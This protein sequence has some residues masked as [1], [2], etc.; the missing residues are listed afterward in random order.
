M[1]NKVVTKLLGLAILL[2]AGAGT[3]QALDASHF[4]TTSKLA[5]GKWVKIAIPESGMYELTSTELAEMGFSSIANV[6][7]YGVG[8]N[9]ISEVLDGSAPDDLQPV[10]VGRTGNK[11]FFYANG[12]VSFSMTNYNSTTLPTQFTRIIN[13]YSNYGYYFLTESTG[14]DNTVSTAAAATVTNPA[15]KTSSLGYWRH[16][17]ELMSVG[18]SGKEFMGEDFTNEVL[19]IPYSI[20]NLVG[21]Q[22]TVQTDVAANA[23]ALSYVSTC[24]HSGSATD[25]V[26][27]SLSASKI[28]VPASVYVFYNEASPTA[29]VTL[30]DPQPEGYLQPGIN[31]SSATANLL[32]AKL[33]YFIITYPRLNVLPTDDAQGHQLLM[34]FD[35][36]TNTDRVVLPGASATTQVWNITNHNSPVAMPLTTVDGGRAFTNGN[37]ADYLIYM[38][39][40]PAQTLK[41]IA[42]YKHVENQNLHAATTPDMVIVTNSYFHEQAQRIAD[43][44]TAKDGMTVLVVD[45]EKI[46]NEFSSGTPDAMGIRMFNKMLYDRNPSKLK[47]LLMFGPGSYDNRGLL[48][49][50]EN[51]ILTYESDNSNDEDYSIVT[52]DFFAFLADNSG[53]SLASDRLTLGVGRFPV[54][55]LSEAQS[56]VDKLIGYYTNPDYGVWRNNVMISSD[57]GDNFTHLFQ[58]ESVGKIID[59]NAGMQINK[60]HNSMYPKAV[61][62]TTLSESRRSASTARQHWRDL[63]KQG[64]YFMTYVGHGG[65]TGYTKHSYMWTTSDVTGTTYNHYPVMTVAAC[66]VARYDSDQRGVAELAFHHPNGGAIAVLATARQ[67]YGEWNDKLNRAFTDAMFSFSN[68]GTMPRLGDAYLACKT[69]FTSS[70]RNKLHWHLMGDPAMKVNYP[71]PYFKITKI[72]GVDVT[73]ASAT[74]DVYPLSQLTVE[75]KVLAADGKNVNTAFNGDATVTLYDISRRFTTLTQKVDGVSEERPIY[76]ERNRLAEVTGRVVNGVFNGTLVVPLQVKSPADERDYHN[77]PQ[78]RVYAH[79]DNSEEMVNGSSD[80]MKF[81]LYNASQAI[82]D[83][84]A[85]TVT[86]M[87]FN[88]EESFSDGAIVP[89]NSTIY[90]TAVDDIAIS[91][92]EMAVGKTMSLKLDGGKKSYTEI[93]DFI[94]TSNGGKELSIAFPISDLEDGNHTLTF[95]VYDAAGNSATRTIAFAVGQDNG[96]A[97]T[98]SVAPATMG[99]P[100]DFDFSSTLTT[101]PQVVVRV[102]DATGNVVWKTTTSSF[103][104]TW[105]QKDSSGKQVPAGLYKYFGTYSDGTNYGGTPI[106]NLVVLEALKT[107][108]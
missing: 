90:I 86:S 22:I 41:K 45:Q 33:N 34:G 95:T 6:R 27:F 2:F 89:A 15:D 84:V 13:P 32:T 38:A 60:V 9:R 96:A 40:D 83:N 36:P 88:D 11:I 104:V 21:N 93:K 51:Y 12:P 63:S 23:T 72:N 100:I 59:N 87:F 50:R 71:K 98:A 91:T 39:F 4:A 66:D 16:E 64:Q 26:P 80:Q 81:N 25:T 55:D 1:R 30:T 48:G 70:N 35:S 29:T 24:V 54:A 61:D 106:Y 58:A 62:E 78:L 101:S 46:F 94:V 37:N 28:F 56:A 103:P 68:N 79:K 69:V 92:Q 44:H 18:F 43:M 74:A 67:V 57:E 20:P 52:D 8:G 75:A 65:P 3:A 73:D 85:P 14:A 97:M 77:I 10:A 102:T 19:R 7:V 49:N 17:N 108:N 76:Y 99:T 47:Y 105:N 53:Q 107:N 42:N 82:T 5:S 31:L